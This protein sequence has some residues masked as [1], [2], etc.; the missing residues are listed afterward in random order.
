M[1]IISYN[2]NGIRSAMQKGLSE[3]VAEQQADVLCFQELKASLPDINQAVFQ[4]M[5]YHTY[6]F[7][8][9]KKGYSGVGILSKAKPDAVTYGCGLPQADEEG[10]VL[11]LRFGDLQLINTYFPSGSSGEDR[12][13]YKMQFLGEYLAYLKQQFNLQKDQSSILCSKR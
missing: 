1:K 6:W 4:D 8:A 2:L 10:R 5:G 9:Q 11:Q 12:Q 13:A 7:P 3:W